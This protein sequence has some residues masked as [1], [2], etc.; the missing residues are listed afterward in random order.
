VE[1][2]VEERVEEE[3][4]VVEAVLDW[5][6]EDVLLDEEVWTVEL[7]D[8]ESVEDVVLLIV[9]ESFVFVLEAV[10]E[11]EDVLLLVTLLEVLETAAELVDE[12]VWTLELLEEDE[13]V[14]DVELV[15]DEEEVVLEVSGTPPG[16]AT[17]CRMF[18]VVEPNTAG[19]RES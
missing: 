3:D 4:F 17:I 7:L 19:A 14:E 16:P 15:E 10:L 8:E 12:E 2:V 6:E 11:V 18:S 9:D 1:V 13:I 5:V